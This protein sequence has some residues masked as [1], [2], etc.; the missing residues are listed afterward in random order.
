MDNKNQHS[1][2]RMVEEYRYTQTVIKHDDW[3]D[4]GTSGQANFDSSCP[5][6]FEIPEDEVSEDFLHFWERWIVSR[7]GGDTYT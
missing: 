5:I 1:L 3:H 2:A 4:H 7:C 6:C